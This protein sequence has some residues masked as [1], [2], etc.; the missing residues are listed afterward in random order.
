MLPHEHR[1]THYC[2]PARY[3]GPA[4]GYRFCYARPRC[5]PPPALPTHTV[6]PRLCRYT[7]YPHHRPA[8]YT[9]PRSGRSTPGC[10]ACKRRVP[11]L[12]ARTLAY[13]GRFAPRTTHC[14]CAPLYGLH[15]SGA[16][17]L[18]LSHLPPTPPDRCLATFA[19]F[20]TLP[21]P[22]VAPHARMPAS[23]TRLDYRYAYA[24]VWHFAANGLR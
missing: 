1:P 4:R 5:T 18:P 2:T 6:I 19:R 13:H 15:G 21:Y 14:R 23:A 22:A 12:P 8:D 3:P 24:W 17:L 16:R 11:R 9:P 20:I 7:T 10:R